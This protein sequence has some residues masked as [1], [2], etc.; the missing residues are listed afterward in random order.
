MTSDL[1]LT[2]ST[3]LG[4]LLALAHGLRVLRYATSPQRRLHERLS[5]LRR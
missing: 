5:Q 3:G 1:L 2:V 4:L